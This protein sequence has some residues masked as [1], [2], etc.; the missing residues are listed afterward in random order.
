MPDSPEPKTTHGSTPHRLDRR[1]FRRR[2]GIGDVVFRVGKFGMGKPVRGELGD[3]SPDGA[4]VTLPVEIQEGAELEIEFTGVGSFKSLTIRAIVRKVMTTEDGRWTAGV[5][6][7]R[8]MPY[9]FL[10]QLSR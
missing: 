10:N 1:A 3:L 8:R 7:E 9:E 5:R 6:F 4:S 2:E